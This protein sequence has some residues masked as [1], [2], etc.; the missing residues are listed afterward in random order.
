ML[1]EYV[2]Y[3]CTQTKTCADTDVLVP[4]KIAYKCSTC[5]YVSG[6]GETPYDTFDVQQ[7]AAGVRTRFLPGRHLSCGHASQVTALSWQRNPSHKYAP[8]PPPGLLYRDGGLCH[9]FTP[10]SVLEVCSWSVLAEVV[11]LAVLQS[12]S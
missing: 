1:Y 8:P 5:T 9:V 4:F 7:I 6:T 3:V 11:S 12:V 2:H 10:Q